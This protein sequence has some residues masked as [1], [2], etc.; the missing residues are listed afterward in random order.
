MRDSHDLAESE[1]SKREVDILI[2]SE[3]NKTLAT[4]KQWLVDEE[5]NVALVV[6]NSFLPTGK[7]GRGRGFAWVETG[8]YRVY[9][10]YISP[11]VDTG[12]F[13]AY[14]EDLGSS[15]RG[16]QAKVILGGTSTLSHSSGERNKT[17]EERYL[18]TGCHSNSSR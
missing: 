18:P 7:R 2:I 9:S 8:A 3:P 15:I 12:V 4:Q 10:C 6:R 1:A 13:E 16:T 17:R 14:L 5:T 11:N